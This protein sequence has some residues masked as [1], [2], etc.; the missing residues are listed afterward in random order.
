MS[1]KRIE[2]LGVPVD[3]CSPDE[4]APA[5]LQILEKPGAKQIVFLSIWDLIR[6]RKRKSELG[7]CLKN[8]DLVL[9]VSKSI[10]SG[11][12]F[13]G[14]KLIPIRYNPF[15]ATILMLSILDQYYK[16]LFLLGGR[17]KTLQ[18]AERNVH[19]TFPN[20]RIVG[21]YVGYFP[22]NSEQSV[23]TAI[24][25][26][27]PSLAI[28]SEGIKEKNLWAF[29]RR[30]QF[31]SSIFLFYADCLG[32]FSKRI[33]RVSEKTFEKGMEVLNEIAH[34]PFKIFYVFPFIYYIISLLWCKFF[35]KKSNDSLD[36]SEEVA[37]DK[38]N[39]KEKEPFVREISEEAV[40]SLE[41]E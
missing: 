35:K 20:L 10:I 40:D 7:E 5:L 11:V 16:T 2:L 24:H 18:Q 12:K 19:E 1:L 31:S 41:L 30:E 8:A 29:R 23:V 36:E 9:P 22:K 27:A 15:D 34:N 17:K 13:L 26:A 28:L 21:R 39:P 33:K 3:V 4:L 38:Q 14:I 25:K 6:A 32:I 37:E